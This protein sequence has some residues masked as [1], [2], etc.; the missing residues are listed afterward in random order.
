MRYEV[1]HLPNENPPI[2]PFSKGGNE[3]HH[4]RLF[5]NGGNENP[6]NIPLLKGGKGGFFVVRGGRP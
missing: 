2:P 6:P 5:A 3:N 1:M 4:I